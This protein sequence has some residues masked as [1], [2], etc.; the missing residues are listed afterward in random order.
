MVIFIARIKYG[1]TMTKIFRKFS[2]LFLITIGFT[3]KCYAQD[4][5][6]KSLQKKYEYYFNENKLDSALFF[7]KKMNSW[8]Y[9]NESDTSLRYAISCRFIG[10]CFVSPDS[11]IYY[12]DRSLKLL[13]KQKR[14]VHV[15]YAKGLNNIANVYKNSVD[16]DEAEK[17]YRD[18]IIIF[19][20]LIEKKY[21]DRFY[22]ITSLNLSRLYYFEKEQFEKV[23]GPILKAIYNSNSFIDKMN[24]NLAD[25]YD[26]LANYYRRTSHF[27]K[28]IDYF[29]KAIEIFDYHNL[30]NSPA[31]ANTLNNMGL[32]Y[33][34]MHDIKSAENH[35]LKAMEINTKV[36]GEND[37]SVA[38]NF[39]NLSSIKTSESEYDM[40][41]TYQEKSNQIIKNIYG[42]NHPEYAKGMVSMGILY[43][44]MGEI[45][46]GLSYFQDALKIDNIKNSFKANIF[47][48]LGTIYMRGA[49][50]EDAILNFNCCLL[51]Y[52]EIFTEE[53]LDIAYVYHNL[54][55]LYKSL[56]N[57]DKA[58]EFHTK[59]Y[60]LRRKLLLSNNPEIAFSLNG[61][62]YCYRDLGNLEKAKKYSF[63]AL[64][65]L[66][67]S[68]VSKKVNEEIA[69]TFSNLSRIYSNDGEFEQALTY[70]KDALKI[71]INIFGWKYRSTA[72]SLNNL[73]ILYYRINQL[74]SAEYYQKKSIEMFD[75]P[76]FK[77]NLAILYFEKGNYTE[78]QKLL[79]QVLSFDLKH[80]NPN[81]PHLGETYFRIGRNCFYQNDY[82]NAEK[83]F[84]KS[85]EI[86]TSNI[87]HNF[88]FLSNEERKLFW[89]DNQFF[90][91]YLNYYG[92]KS[93]LFSPEVTTLNY[94][95]N[96]FSKS[97]LLET[98]RELDQAISNSSDKLSKAQYTEMKQLRR[99]VS[100]L[101]SEGS[102]KKEIFD[103]YNHQADSLDKI[104]VNKLG[105]YANAKRKFEITWK[106]VRSNLS[107]TEAAIEFARFYD[108]EDT[109]YKYMALV[110]RPEYEYPKLVK[111]GTEPQIKNASSQKEFSE[112]Y[113]YVWSGI[114][115]LLSVVKTIY[116]SPVGE[117]NNVSFS[118][119]INENK[120]QSDSSKSN[121][122]YLMDRYDLHQVT[123]TRYLADGT[124]KRNDSLPL[125]V[126]LIG[127]VNY[128][129]LPTVK[130]SVHITE[131]TEDLALQ[132]NLQNELIDNKSNRGGKISYL[133]GSEIEVKEIAKTLKNSGWETTISDGKNAGEYQF[134][135][136]L[137]VKSPG[138][139]HISTHG[140]A[141]PD[142][143][144][145]ETNNFE[146]QERSTYK[147]SEDPMVRCGLMLSGASI[148]WSG[149]SK[150][151]IETTGDDGILTAAEVANMD[152][153]N[154]KLVV[155]SACET[156]L[157]KIESSEGTFGLKRGFKLAGVEQI[158]VS[159]W[160]VPDNETMELMT[161]FYS[162]LAKTNNPEVSFNFAQ[163]AMRNKFPYEPEKWAGF[164]FVR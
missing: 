47:F 25:C 99:I 118:A 18:A 46:K 55:S 96:L 65:I 95:N 112:L 40:A 19:E 94:N 158:I 142:R 82:F 58:I 117:L 90:I 104:L 73:G 149:D 111:L 35:F 67:L 150:K 121:W 22:L 71:N 64:E 12:Y 60:N 27:E 5:D 68:N 138:I 74:D 136:E 21:F 48:N 114:D 147:I 108:Y 162:D 41:I 80:L 163:K 34:E 152:L 79:N 133:K 145:K 39:S 53:N 110:V 51:I 38:D 66:K 164:V 159:L 36:L 105:E 6:Y 33:M 3:V 81:H 131:S 161:L 113:K 7:A 120:N 141:F 129:D 146:T 91:D 134:K 155:L 11:A 26:F 160:K 45:K 1:T 132:I 84:V 50:Y 140:F 59:A 87:A 123:T 115:S 43:S 130:D 137:N 2:F 128:A 153:S 124:L 70:A 29:E 44:T 83:S 37:E 101:Q 102:D 30:N 144:N 20:K 88:S 89:Y 76:Y 54:G 52:K 49:Q 10:N 24:L 78:A 14:E 107:T 135:S 9:I 151:M 106:D 15:D 63:E 157:G 85:A 148:S 100:K 92:S 32:L 16:F 109:T 23:E 56:A 93:F 98:S 57:F 127:G 75:E 126:K 77:T 42:S 31:Y 125:S 62:S 72:V 156:G 154:T 143:E 28:A 122:S 119:L 13:K 17:Y 116:Y 97:L 139:I 69:A 103:R 86:K 8:A 4:T 61:I